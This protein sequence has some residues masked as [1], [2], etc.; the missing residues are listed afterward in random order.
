MGHEGCKDPHNP[1]PDAKHGQGVG[2]WA[3]TDPRT[4]LQLATIQGPFPIHLSASIGSE[5]TPHLFDLL[6]HAP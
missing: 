1:W 5:R 2:G 3:A 6:L 4:Q